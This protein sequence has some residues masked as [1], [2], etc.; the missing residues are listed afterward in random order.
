M[1]NSLVML[2]VWL[3]WGLA[4][5]VAAFSTYMLAIL[6][7]ALLGRGHRSMPAPAARKIAVVVPAHD[8]EAG[9]G[10]TITQILGTD[11]PAQLL[12]LIVIADNCTDGTEAVAKAA[13]AM[14][15]QRTDTTNRGKGQALGWAL[16]EHADLF[17]DRDLIAF[18]DADMNVHPGFFR[19]MASEFEDASLQIAQGRYI[20]SNPE[21]SVLSAI[22][23]A[24]FC[25][26]NDVRP[27]GRC[28][29]GGTCDL[30]GSGMVFRAGFLQE[31]GW[32][33]HSIAEDIQLSKELLLKGV[34]VRY[35]P[36]ARIESDIPSTLGQVEVQQ[37]RWEGG[38]QEVIASLFPRTVRALASRP[39]IALLDGLFDM[40]VPPISVVVALNAVGILASLL[41]GSGALPVFAASL[42]VFL[43]AV[44]AGLLRNNASAGVYQRLVCAP[45]FIVWKLFLLAK[46]RLAPAATAWVRTPRD[47]SRE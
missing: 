8:E 29:F 38:R 32:S 22:G 5:Y 15:L 40:L 17:A 23:F 18:I 21:K 13:G 37:S 41:T 35:V 19:A 9:I 20:I 44:L 24:S 27:A 14:V 47:R 10:N 42:L 12:R 36:D 30:K 6:A 7:G 2:G 34:L 33:A 4:L 26:V 25:Y 46:L 31:H 11:Y 28:R 1:V 43:G 16:R 45:V 3:A 39:S